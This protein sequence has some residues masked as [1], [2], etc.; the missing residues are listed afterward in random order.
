MTIPLFFYFDLGNVLLLFDH[1]IACRQMAA[2]AGVTAERVRE[3]VFDSDLEWRYERGDV[4]SR[5]FY[6]IFCDATGTRPDYAALQYAGSA[7]FELNHEIVPIV[8]GLKAA[9]AR[10]GI[11]SNTCESH[12][13]YATDGRYELFNSMFDLFALSFEIGAM[14]PEPAIYAAA[15]E[16]A[17][18]P[19]HAIFFVDD[20]PENVAGAREAGFDAVLYTSVSGLADELRKRQ[21]LL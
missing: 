12:W 19:P 3:V 8:S 15:A 6:D 21:I 4:T 9:R 11:L 17:G 1:A 7:I 20:R 16:L 5:E 10:L 18:V 13:Q 2:V 14:K